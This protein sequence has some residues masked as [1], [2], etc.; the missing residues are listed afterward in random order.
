M[1][2]QLS[3]L[4]LSSLLAAG[5]TLC[6]AA[7]FAQQ[8]NAAPGAQQPATGQGQWGH[9]HMDPDQ[10]VAHMAKR[11]SLTSD[12][13]AQIKPILANRQ[14]QMQALR[15]DTTLSR[16]DK[17]AKVKGIRDDSSSKIQAVLNDTQKQ[18]FA[19]DQQRRQER[20]QQHN[21]APTAGPTA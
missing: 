20:M 7:A 15:Q 10:Q 21:A 6:S 14:Q 19:A 11:Y 9:K 16:E 17:I 4:A 18:K 5:L 12:Q 2:N 1:K 13:Q 3:R 8:D